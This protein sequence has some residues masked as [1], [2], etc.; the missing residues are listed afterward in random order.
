[1]EEEQRAKKYPYKCDTLQNLTVDAAGYLI[2]KVAFDT[3][4]LFNVS[5]LVG[6]IAYDWHSHRLRS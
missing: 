2:L 6:D 4:Y 1:M 5:G 3:E